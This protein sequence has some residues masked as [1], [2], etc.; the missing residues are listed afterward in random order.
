MN[1]FVKNPTFSLLSLKSKNIEKIIKNINR[2]AATKGQKLLSE[3]L[4]VAN[5]KAP[6]APT[7][8]ASVGVAKPD[9]IEPK[10]DIIKKRGGKRISNI[11]FL[12]LEFSSFLIT[13]GI[14]D[15]SVNDFTIW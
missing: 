13:L 5:N 10:T 7:D 12:F 6:I 2:A 3:V 14:E 15:G 8:A 9:K 1:K 4:Y 11:F